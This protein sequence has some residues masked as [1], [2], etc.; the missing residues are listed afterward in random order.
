MQALEAIAAL[1]PLFHVENVAHEFVI[2]LARV[3]LQFRR[4]FLDGTERFHHQHGMMRHDRASA[5]A[6]DRR[7]RDAFRIAN[8][9]DVPNHV[10][11]VFLE[12]I[13]GRA[14]EIAAR[15]VVIDA[16]PAADIQITE[17]VPKFRKLCVIARRFAH[18]AFDR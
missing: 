14:I 1:E 17:L 3:D 4:R 16:E 9:H 11:G 12:R 6:H 15:T 10:V 5:F 8:V 2:L 13:I 18:R 7:M